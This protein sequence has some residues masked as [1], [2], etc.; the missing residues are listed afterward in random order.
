MVAAVQTSVPSLFVNAARVRNLRGP[1]SVPVEPVYTIHAQFK[2]IHGV[3]SR[4]AGVPL[5]KLRVLDNLI[6][7][8]L[9]YRESLPSGMQLTVLPEGEMEPLMAALEE[10]LR[11]RVLETRASFGG[12][13]PETGMLIDLAA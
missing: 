12:L 9:A 8:L 2:H 13:F 5:F 10:R 11:T 7:R 3:P 4:G 6:D 1:I